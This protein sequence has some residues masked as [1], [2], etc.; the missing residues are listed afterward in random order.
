MLAKAGLGR[1]HDDYPPRVRPAMLTKGTALTEIGTA[2]AVTGFHHFSPTVSDV[3]SSAR[4][5]ERVFG[6]SR[7][8]LS[9]PH[10]GAEADGYAV[11]LMDPRSGIAIGLHHHEANPGEPFHESRTGLDHISFGVAE[12][13]DL[14]AWATWLNELGIENSG[15]IDTDNPLPYSVVVFRDPDNIQLELFHMAS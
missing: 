14:D 15:V 6:M 2:P 7:V 3:E 10:Y 8:P 5:Y 12:R 11:L 1:H 13:A 4:W 9:F